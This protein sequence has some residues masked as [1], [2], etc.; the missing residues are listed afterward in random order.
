METTVAQQVALNKS[1]KECNQSFSITHGELAFLRE[2][3]GEDFSEPV[4]CKA[5]RSRK[6]HMKEAVGR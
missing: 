4:R 3:F 5:C 6:K 1:C 2:R